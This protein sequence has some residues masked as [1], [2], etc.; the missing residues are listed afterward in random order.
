MSFLPPLCQWLTRLTHL[1]WG[2]STLCPTRR[3][4]PTTRRARP[5]PA[6]RRPCPPLSHPS[7]SARRGASRR[8]LRASL[9]RRRPPS[10]GRA[11]T[12]RLTPPSSRVAL[13]PPPPPSRPPPPRR[14]GPRRVAL[15]PGLPKARRAWGSPGEALRPGVPPP[16]RTAPPSM[17]SGAS[18]RPPLPRSKSHGVARSSRK[19]LI[20]APLIANVSATGTASA[21]ATRASVP[22]GRLAMR[23]AAM[24][25]AFLTVP[26]RTP[27]HGMPGA[28]ARPRPGLRSRPRLRRP[29]PL[30][31]A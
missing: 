11:A 9:P 26:P 29:R 30:S 5:R 24:Q 2:T 8:L 20:A 28:P 31:H 1:T 6:R 16:S 19:K 10:G 21:S 25:L 27:V 14:R 15:L 18:P 17:A 4:L 3:R 12:R 23:L 13:F 7:S 22:N